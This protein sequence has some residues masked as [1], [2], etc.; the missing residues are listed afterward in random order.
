MAAAAV[1]SPSVM[2]LWE[3]KIPSPPTSDSPFF[4]FKVR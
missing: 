3:E 1:L 4:P 2:M